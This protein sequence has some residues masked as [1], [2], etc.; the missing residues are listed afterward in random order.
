MKVLVTGASG[1]VG[2]ELIAQLRANGDQAIA[3]VRRPAKNENELSY[4]VGGTAL[5]NSALDEA[6]M[7]ADA[8]V[9][10]AGATTG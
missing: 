6:I 1:L 8:V 10:L 7:T 4:V 2:T 3:L 5:Q 9:N